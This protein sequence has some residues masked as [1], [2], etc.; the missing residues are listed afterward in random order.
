KSR[1]GSFRRAE[2]HKR[3][4]RRHTSSL[5]PARARRIPL[6]CAT[7]NRKFESPFLF[8]RQNKFS[9]LNERVLVEKRNKKFQFG[10]GWLPDNS[11]PD[12]LKEVLALD[13]ALIFD[14]ILNGHESLFTQVA[15]RFTPHFFFP[16]FYDTAGRI[17]RQD[18]FTFD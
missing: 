8:P 12:R 16:C 6:S 14:L 5:C 11:D 4:D 1:P 13:L 15:L 10:A 2:N 17:P 9:T 18:L 7:S 3:L